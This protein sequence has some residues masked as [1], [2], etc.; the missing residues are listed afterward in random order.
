MTITKKEL[1][2]T[3]QRTTELLW[4][5]NALATNGDDAQHVSC[6]SEGCVIKIRKDSAILAHQLCHVL[7]ITG[8]VLKVLDRKGESGYLSFRAHK[9]IPAS[10]VA[11]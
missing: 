4:A 10:R 9:P 1:N 11:S 7:S 3:H 5:I 6:E 2:S 8:L